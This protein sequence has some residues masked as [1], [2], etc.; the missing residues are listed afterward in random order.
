[1]TRTQTIIFGVLL[2]MA[3]AFGGYWAAQV[4]GPR[5]PIDASSADAA[6]MCVRLARD[7]QS[8]SSNWAIASWVIGLLATLL[9]VLGGIVGQGPAGSP[10]YQRGA[11]VLLA[12]VGSI[13][14]A[15]AAYSVA[16]SNAASSAAAAAT[17]ALGEPDRASAYRK[18]LD[19]KAQWLASRTDSLDQSPPPA[20]KGSHS[21]PASASAQG[22]PAASGD[23]RP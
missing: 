12:S 3:S 2:A 11:G 9:S 7:L 4:A 1:M 23:G 6:A 18:C 22:A 14:S 10:W 5:G 16:R 8:A 13:L 17:L 19:A 21:A 20:T 15:T